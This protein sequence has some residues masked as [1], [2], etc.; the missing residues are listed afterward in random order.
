MVQEQGKEEGQE[1][2]SSF[3]PVPSWVQDRDFTSPP[4]GEDRVIHSVL[5]PASLSAESIPQTN[6]V[7][8]IKA[9]RFAQLAREK[10]AVAAGRE[11]GIGDWKQ[12]VCREDVR[13]KVMEILQ[14]HTLP[15]AARKALVR[16]GFNKLALEGL[17]SSDPAAKKVALDAL[18]SIAA[19]QE[20]NINQ[21]A[22]QTVNINLGLLSKV[23]ETATLPDEGVWEEEK[24]GEVT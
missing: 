6:T 10:G 20:V 4:T 14:A 17:A 3:L 23:M 12:F 2:V 19:D 22:E 13:E 7:M 16:A 24:T 5:A 1:E 9:A 21:A 15:A 18:K 11:M 8:A